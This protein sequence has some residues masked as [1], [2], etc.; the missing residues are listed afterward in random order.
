MCAHVDPRAT[1]AADEAT[2]PEKPSRK[3][4]TITAGWTDATNINKEN[5]TSLRSWLGETL[6]HIDEESSAEEIVMIDSS[7]Y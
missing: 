4:S 7:N 5:A 6:P 3:L 1:P 2:Q